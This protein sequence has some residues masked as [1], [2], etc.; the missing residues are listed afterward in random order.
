M[1]TGIHIF[2]STVRSYKSSKES[3]SSTLPHGQTVA[4]LSVGHFTH[5]YP[6]N[7]VENATVEKLNAQLNSTYIKRNLEMFSSFNNRFFRSETGHTSAEWLLAQVRGYITEQSPVT[8]SVLQHAYR[9]NS[10]I[11]TIP[12]KSAKTIVVGAHQTPSTQKPSNTG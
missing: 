2:N 4:S 3:T 10:I 12:G 5:A 9:Q 6:T 7:L 1:L 8:I 11:A